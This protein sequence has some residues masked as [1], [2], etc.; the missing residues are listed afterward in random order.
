VK[1]RQR[2]PRIVVPI[3][4]CHA[5]A[6]VPRRLAASPLLVCVDY[7]KCYWASAG[8]CGMTQSPLAGS[9]GQSQSLGAKCFGKGSLIWAS[10]V[11]DEGCSKHAFL[12]ESKTFICIVCVCVNELW[13][14]KPFWC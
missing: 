12:L 5:S 1:E 4:D 9:P 10:G 2:F 8:M 7:H 11:L 6:V 13:A 14:I 3:E